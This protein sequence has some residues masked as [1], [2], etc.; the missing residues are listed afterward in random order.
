RSK[1]YQ[2]TSLSISE[3]RNK[4]DRLDT[5]LTKIRQCFSAP[6]SLNYREI[7]STAIYP[8]FFPL[9]S[10][11]QGLQRVLFFEDLG[12]GKRPRAEEKLWAKSVWFSGL[13][14]RQAFIMWLANL[15]RLPTNI[16]LA[17]CGLNIQT[18]CLSA[19]ITTN[20]ETT[21]SSTVLT[22]RCPGTGSSNGE[23]LI[24]RLS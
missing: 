4:R 3:R 10:S 7:T 9:G 18:A 22:P 15:N 23:T 2:I 5:S 20:H 19:A 24:V 13:I 17:S 11:G 21:C 16:R 1:I 14:P 8:R 12:G 6:Y